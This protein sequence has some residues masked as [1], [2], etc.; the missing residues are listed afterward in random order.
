MDRT[1]SKC[2]TSSSTAEVTPP[3]SARKSSEGNDVPD[4]KIG[5]KFLASVVGGGFEEGTVIK[6]P[7][8]V[9]LDSGE[10][11]T[12]WIVQYVSGRQQDLT[13]Q[14]ILRFSTEKFDEDKDPSDD[15]DPITDDSRPG[16]LKRRY[17]SEQHRPVRSSKRTIRPPAAF[18]E[19]SF[20]QSRESQRAKK[21]QVASV[22]LFKT[23]KTSLLFMPG[24]SEEEAQEALQAVGHPYGLNSA[25]AYIREKRGKTDTY[26]NRAKFMPHAG[27]GVRVGDGRTQ[28]LGQV[29]SEGRMK[30]IDGGKLRMWEVT[31]EDGEKE[32][33][34]WRQLFEARADRPRRTTQNLSGRPLE[35]LEIF[36]GR[37][38]VSQQFAQRMWTTRGADTSPIST[39]DSSNKWTPDFI[40]ACPP[41]FSYSRDEQNQLFKGMVQILHQSKR[42]HKHLIAVIENPFGLLYDIPIMKALE[43]SFGLRRITLNYCGFGQC[44][45][46]PTYL[47]TS[48]RQ[49]RDIRG[50]GASVAY[51]Y[52]HISH[53]R[54]F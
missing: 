52:F 49:M 4:V 15:D 10:F 17:D 24:I 46:R 36:S 27:M 54:S 1:P 9:E 34:D 31:Y 40:W 47:W 44:N 22:D 21:T 12:A 33:L 5:Y 23:A 25:M 14:E 39:A 8:E 3:P 41:C 29:T 38:I 53:S 43:K 11:S 18:I 30:E 26:T 37:G 28:C 16:D 45:H 50:L 6:G 20:M 42:N 32:E 2:T 35:C 51:E 48:V 7:I 19:E 13:V